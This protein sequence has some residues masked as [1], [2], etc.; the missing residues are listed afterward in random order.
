MPIYL[1]IFFLMEW[2]GT[3]SI[4]TAHTERGGKEVTIL[5][6]D[7]LKHRVSGDYFRTHGKRAG[8]GYLEYLRDMEQKGHDI[9]FN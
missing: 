1:G 9:P 5:Y 4:V 7:G 8:D 2:D 3:E 6:R